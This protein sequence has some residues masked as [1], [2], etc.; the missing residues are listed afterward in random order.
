[1]SI[2]VTEV[3]GPPPEERAAPIKNYA[4]FFNTRDLPGI[5][6]VRAFVGCNGMAV[7]TDEQWSGATLAEV[8]ALLPTG[9]QC[10]ARDPRDDPAIVETWL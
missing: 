5:Y 2:G 10:L 7:P 3:N 4:V 8:R 6:V 9:L 1:M